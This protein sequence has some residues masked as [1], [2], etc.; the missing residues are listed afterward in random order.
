MGQIISHKDDA[1]PD[2][3]NEICFSCGESPVAFWMGAT[4]LVSVCR[5][6]AIQVLPC[7]IA[8]AIW[9]QCDM[10]IPIAQN[11]LTEV[12]ERFW[13]AVACN[14]RMARTRQLKERFS[15]GET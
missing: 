3:K 13:Y 12:R 5:T 2:F 7:L 4:G 15:D 14:E 6:C 10:S 8:D 1:Y 11:A 9:Q